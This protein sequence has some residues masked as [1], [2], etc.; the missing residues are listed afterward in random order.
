[1]RREQ[2]EEL[3]RKLGLNKV[4][5]YRYIFKWLMGSIYKGKLLL[6]M[7]TKVADTC[8]YLTHTN[9]QGEDGLL[10]HTNIT[11]ESQEV[12]SPNIFSSQIVQKLH[13]RSFTTRRIADSASTNINNMTNDLL[14]HS[15]T[16]AL[17]EWY[18]PLLIW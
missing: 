17:L 13:V 14:N 12:L 1:M 4:I 2:N 16:T 10:N 18:F 6:K 11:A 15:Q 3:K 9:S 7:L 5:M 8:K